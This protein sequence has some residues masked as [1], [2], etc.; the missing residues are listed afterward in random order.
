MAVNGVEI[1]VGQVWRSRDGSI[2]T[3]C[4]VNQHPYSSLEYPWRVEFN[5][6]GCI[7]NVSMTD[8]GRYWADDARDAGDH[9]NDLMF[10]VSDPDVGKERRVAQTENP[11][12]RRKDDS[13]PVPADLPDLA[14]SPA[15]FAASVPGVLGV[16][17]DPL[18][19]GMRQIGAR[20]EAMCEAQRLGPKVQADSAAKKAEATHYVLTNSFASDEVAAAIGA[21]PFVPAHLEETAYSASLELMRQAAFRTARH[22]GLPCYPGSDEADRAVCSVLSSTGYSYHGGEFWETPR[23]PAPAPT[24][25]KGAL[26]V[27]VGGDHYRSMAIQPVEFIERNGLDFLAGNVVKYVSRHKTKNGA[28]DIRKAMHYCQLIL[29]LQYG[30]KAQ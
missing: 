23:A 21:K 3:V 2:G 11:P 20:I 28:A 12:L 25:P 24:E 29:E 16:L 17:D 15:D 7:S 10:L 26:G 8:E 30:E 4:E 5:Y 6:G 27:Q 1:K 13:P 22:L 18:A 9:P 14:A 19:R